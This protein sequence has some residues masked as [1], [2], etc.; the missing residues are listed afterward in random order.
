MNHILIWVSMCINRFILN[1]ASSNLLS[2]G[3]RIDFSNIS[4]D[5]LL[6]ERCRLPSGLYFSMSF[7]ELFANSSSGSS[8]QPGLQD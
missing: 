3:R 8:Q 7:L 5:I 6:L 4:I 2:E 1:L